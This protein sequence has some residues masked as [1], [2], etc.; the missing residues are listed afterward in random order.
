MDGVTHAVIM[1]HV[2]LW[3]LSLLHS[4]GGHAAYGVIVTIVTPCDVVVAVPVMLYSAT[5][6]VIVLRWELSLS[7]WSV[8]V[9]K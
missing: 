4:Y 7:L 9:P 2:V 3:V 8:V 1:L 5:A 6:I